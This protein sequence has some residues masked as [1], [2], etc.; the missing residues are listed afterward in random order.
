MNEGE[1]T[2]KDWKTKKPAVEE[3][4]VHFSY[5][6]GEIEEKQFGS[7]E[8]TAQEPRVSLTEEGVRVT[9]AEVGVG[10]TKRTRRIWKRNL[11]G[12][13]RIMVCG[14]FKRGRKKQEA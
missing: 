9:V 14:G 4:K 7:E 2:S 10:R 1:V 3:V 8:E 6:S 13:L 12:V 5:V 11:W